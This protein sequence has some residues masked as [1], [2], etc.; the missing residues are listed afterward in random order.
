MAAF[1]PDN[2]SIV[3]YCTKSY[4]ILSK[5]EIIETIEVQSQTRRKELFNKEH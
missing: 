2:V 1:N 4:G 3:L 5:M